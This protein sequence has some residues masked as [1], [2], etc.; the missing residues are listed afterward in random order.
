MLEILFFQSKSRPIYVYSLLAV[1]L[2][3]SEIVV[4]SDEELEKYIVGIIKF[5]VLGVIWDG[6]S[7]S[8]LEGEK[9]LNI[10]LHVMQ[11]C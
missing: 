6:F 3:N 11:K 2:S 10:H 5:I 1:V 9:L 4:P 8:Q 7:C